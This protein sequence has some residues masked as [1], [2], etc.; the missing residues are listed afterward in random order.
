MLNR[1]GL[2]LVKYAAF[3]QLNFIT[4]PRIKPLA[5]PLTIVNASNQLK[6]MSGEA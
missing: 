4:M 6:T 1:N 5:P 2:E 3:N